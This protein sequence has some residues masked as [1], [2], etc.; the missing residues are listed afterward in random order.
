MPLIQL[1]LDI[2]LF[3]KGPKDVPFSGMLLSVA[4]ALNLAVS[5]LLGLFDLDGV[6][7]VMQSVL[8]VLLLTSFLWA[9]LKISHKSSRFIQT[10]AAAIGCDG[11][12]SLAGLLTL[13][14]VHFFPDFA[15]AV[16]IPLLLL[17]L[18]QMAVIGHIV[19]QALSIGF[20]GGMGLALAYT[21]LSFRIMMGMFPPS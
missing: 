2:C 18:W 3:R 19:S 10:A 12:I 17:M 1:F 14:A 15:G 20:W 21:A 6:A 11:L 7:A 16:G 4:I 13:S 9:T 5:I 8:A